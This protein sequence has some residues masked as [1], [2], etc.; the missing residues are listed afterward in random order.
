MKVTLFGATGIVG[1]AVLRHLLDCGYE[2]NVLM[3]RMTKDRSYLHECPTV[4]D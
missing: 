2:V 3:V 1:R 4:S